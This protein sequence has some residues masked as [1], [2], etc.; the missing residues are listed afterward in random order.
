M[1]VASQEEFALALDKANIRLEDSLTADLTAVVRLNWEH[2][3]DY[4]VLARLAFN[5]IVTEEQFLF[6]HEW[7]IWQPSE[8]PYLFSLVTKA[9]FNKELDKRT[10]GVH[11][12]SDDRDAATTLLQLGL[13]SG[14]GGLLLGNG[15]NWFYFDHDQLGLIKSPVNVQELLEGVHGLKI[16]GPAA[17]QTH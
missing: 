13:Q 17:I 6:F 10:E 7:G 3:I 8:N 15:D 5:A 14:W 9:W 16:L 4:A 2:P 12:S 11:F 1:R